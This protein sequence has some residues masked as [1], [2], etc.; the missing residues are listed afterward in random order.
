MQSLII[1]QIIILIYSIIIHEIA[2]GY[3][4]YLFGDR[5]AFYAGRLT[6]N[7]VPHIDPFGSVFLPVMLA[8]QS[9]SGSGLSF[10][11]GWAKPVP[12]NE[13][14][15]NK[16]QS[17]CVSVAGVFV[18]FCLCL[19]FSILGHFSST[20]TLKILCYIVASTNLGLAIFNLIPVPPA[21]GYRILSLFLPINL[22]W[23]IENYI[24][25]YQIAFLIVA[26]ILASII[27]SF[28]FPFFRNILTYFIF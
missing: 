25:Q 26:I 7:P 3:V 15:F 13:T 23:K 17:F 27:F 18:N 14:G 24:N 19:I 4:A 21:D 28:I 12:V 20:E 8:L 6:L 9:F 5:T 2:H 22:K 16:F 10:I 1:F 11:A